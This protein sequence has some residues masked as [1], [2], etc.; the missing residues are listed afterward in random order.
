MES[1]KDSLR[2]IVNLG[3]YQVERVERG[4]FG[5]AFTLALP[6][7]VKIHADLPY[8]ADVRVG[9]WHTLYTEVLADALPSAT[10]IQ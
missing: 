6:N 7:N 4:A 10:P 1:T 2:L 3:K 8:Y 5:T 9:D